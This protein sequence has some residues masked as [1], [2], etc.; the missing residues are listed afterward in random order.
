M[1]AKLALMRERRSATVLSNSM[2]LSTFTGEAK[3]TSFYDLDVATN[4]GY[5]NLWVRCLGQ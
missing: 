4:L 5:S 3:L 1:E 2:A